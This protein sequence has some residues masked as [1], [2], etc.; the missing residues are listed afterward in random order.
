MVTMIQT[1]ALL[2][3]VVLVVALL[4]AWLIWGRGKP[5]RERHRAADV[6]DEGAGPARRNQALIDAPS[7]AARVAAPLGG[8]GV[9][10]GG[11]G[12]VAA[13]AAA[14]EVAAAHQADVAEVVTAPV[15]PGVAGDDLTRLKGVG[16]KLSA[17]L[18][19]LGVVSFAQIAAWS[20]TDL[21]GIDAQ[22]G[23]FAGR[24]TRDGWIEQAQFL[25]A[26]DV[27]GYEAKFGK[28]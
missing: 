15:A 4:V 11:L 18:R 22:L 2:I 23:T 12:D 14:A 17:R 7:A 13:M 19:E 25:A 10:L 28:L 24:P 27:A 26:G 5:V 16:P 6:L 8:S 20:E 3:G 21:A 1:N 9:N